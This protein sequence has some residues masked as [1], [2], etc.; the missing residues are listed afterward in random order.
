[1]AEDPGGC[2]ARLWDPGVANRFNLLVKA[3]GDRYDKHP[4]F[5]GIKFPESIINIDEQTARGYSDA[6]LAAA[7]KGRINSAVQWNSEMLS[8]HSMQFSK[9]V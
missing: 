4:N 3:L 9:R 1:M 6:A 7:M 5:E 8:L 2:I